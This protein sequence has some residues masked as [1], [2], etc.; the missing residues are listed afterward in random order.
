MAK[1]IWP[2]IE[3]AFEAKWPLI[4]P[5][6]AGCKEHGYH[7][8]MNTDKLIADYLADWAVENYQLLVAPTLE[9]N[10]SPAFTEY[11]GSASLP[12]DLSVNMIVELCL[13]WQKQGAKRFYVLNTGISTLHVLAKA[14]IILLEKEVSFNYFDFSD[15]YTHKRIKALTK[16]KVGSHADEIETSIMLYIKPEVVNMSKA[17]AEENPDKLGGLTRD[18]KSIDRTISQTGAWGNPTLA[19]AEKGQ[20]AIDLLKKMLKND[21]NNLTL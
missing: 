21:L 7:L 9:Y 2:E 17:K 10:F 14:A 8:P 18:P 1:A 12:F 19:T 13:C 11:P 15:L 16:Q 4:I 6:G 20:I 3:Q 5:L